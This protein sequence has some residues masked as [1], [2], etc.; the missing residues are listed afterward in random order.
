MILLGV[1]MVS[2]SVG[3]RGSEN[4]PNVIQC[5]W[6]LIHVD[7]IHGVYNRVAVM[8]VIHHYAIYAFYIFL[9]EGYGVDNG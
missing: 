6:W 5:L 8:S 3:I 1:L 2:L 7:D 9:L 4:N